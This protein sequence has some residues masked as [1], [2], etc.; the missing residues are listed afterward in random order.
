MWLC[1][2]II[3]F[4]TI[5]SGLFHWHSSTVNVCADDQNDIRTEMKL[6]SH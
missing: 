4:P 3:R 6:N 2:G 1:E 5:L